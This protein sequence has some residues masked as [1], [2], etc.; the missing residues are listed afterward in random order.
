MSSGQGNVHVGVVG[1]GDIGG[2]IAG[3][4]SRAGF[5]PFVYDLRTEAVDA[6]VDLGAV[7]SESLEDMARRADLISLAVFDDEQVSSVVETMIPHARPGA[8]F[9]VHSTVRPS[10]AV[11]LAEAAREAALDLIDAPVTGGPDKAKLGLL[12]VFVG[13]GD[14]AVER[15]TSLLQVIGSHVF[16]LGP[17]GAGSAAK[18]MNNLLA[19]GGYALQL[20]AMQLGAAYGIDEDT[21]TSFLV[22]GGGDSRGIR[23]WG[24][25]DRFRR[26]HDRL[27]GTP[28]MYEY[29]SKDL[30]E[31]AEAAGERGVIL[32]LTASAGE[33]LPRK[34][35]QRDREFQPTK[36]IPRC[37]GCDQEL[38]LPFRQVG[39]HPECRDLV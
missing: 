39:V 18:L 19:L 36:E 16:H 33:I 1:C 34:L 14:A 32:P 30:R 28:E 7:R 24:S 17:P 11:R 8:I 13:G 6:L 9:I 25:M 29:M 37:A 12:T 2:S 26:S 27:A 35:Q 10:T 21:A 20:E 3:C 23:T 38:A 5:E 31:A 22:V 15:C 4:V